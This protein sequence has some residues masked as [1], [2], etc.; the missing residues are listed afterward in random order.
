MKLKLTVLTLTTLL[1][2]GGSAAIAEEHAGH[3]GMMVMEEVQGEAVASAEA[4]NVGNKICPISGEKVDE[5][6]APFQVEYEGKTYNLCCAMCAKDFNK[7]PEK[8]IQKIN[9]QMMGAEDETDED[10]DMDE[11]MESHGDHDHEGHQ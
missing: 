1:A 9:E 8:Y 5:M 3:E 11:G 10:M 7:D 2:L 6:G 4:I